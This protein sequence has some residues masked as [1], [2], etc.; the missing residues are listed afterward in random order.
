M[1]VLQELEYLQK[2]HERVQKIFKLIKSL[3]Q[4]FYKRKNTFETQEGFIDKNNHILSLYIYNIPG[5]L[6]EKLLH[7]YICNSKNMHHKKNDLW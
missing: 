3:N 6:L 1:E 7:F 5:A 4:S 2:A